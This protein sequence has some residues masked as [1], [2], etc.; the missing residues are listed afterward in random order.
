MLIV[1]LLQPERERKLELNR[2]VGLPAAPDR[3]KC[4]WLGGHRDSPSVY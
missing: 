2:I 3:G 1:N 4:T